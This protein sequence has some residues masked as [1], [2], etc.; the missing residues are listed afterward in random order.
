MAMIDAQKQLS[1]AR[2]ERNERLRIA[3]RVAIVNREPLMMFDAVA[4]HYPPCQETESDSPQ[5]EKWKESFRKMGCHGRLSIATTPCPLQSTKSAPHT[6]HNQYP[7]R[8]AA[9]SA[10]NAGM[11]A[12]QQM[13]DDLDAEM[14]KSSP[15]YSN[16]LRLYGHDTSGFEDM[17][18][19]RR[20][21]ESK[22]YPSY[23][24]FLR[25]RYGHES[26]E[27]GERRN[28]SKHYYIKYSG[29]EK[30]SVPRPIL[31]RKW[32]KEVDE[33]GD[34]DRYKDQTKRIRDLLEASSQRILT[35]G[36]IEEIDAVMMG[37]PTGTD[38]YGRNS[39]LWYA[40]A[41]I[42]TIGAAWVAADFALRSLRP[43]MY[44][45]IDRY[46]AERKLLK[47][48]KKNILMTSQ[49]TTALAAIE[50]ELAELLED[51][52]RDQWELLMGRELP[53]EDEA[54]EGKVEGLDEGR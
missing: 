24:V 26:K 51:Y 36:E 53:Y 43:E 21:E 30:I 4:N 34:P 29:P 35:D 15:N 52:L 7:L 39:L 37:L 50:R 9:E 42:A 1:K 14:L 6:T 20:E 13:Q 47:A 19:S 25:D 38:K 32:L 11:E 2:D 44:R 8:S 17:T 10:Y 27:A 23:V 18:E 16:I 40:G 28:D 54:R 48:A 31:M 3:T 5:N 41:V 22:E 49:S 33:L 46:D 12:V 45:R